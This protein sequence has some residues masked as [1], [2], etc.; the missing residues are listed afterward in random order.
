MAHFFYPIQNICCFVNI[1][2]LSVDNIEHRIFFCLF[3]CLFV[4]LGLNDSF[5][6]FL[7]LFFLFSFFWLNK[8]IS[9]DFSRFLFIWD[10]INFFLIIFSFID[11]RENGRERERNIDW[12]LLACPPWRLGL[13]PGHV[14]CLGIKLATSWCMG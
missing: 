6:F 12:L 5:R 13:Q 8:S 7:F 1:N 11:F 2:Y 3:V 9:N 4:L 10:I 14:S